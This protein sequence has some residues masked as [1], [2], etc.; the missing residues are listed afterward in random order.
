MIG[1]QQR[2]NINIDDVRQYNPSLAAMVLQD[3][4][5]M[6]KL[7]QEQLNQS[8]HAMQDSSQGKGEK[9]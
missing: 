4:V 1:R 5:E 9:A 7:F 3:P 8:I 6:I 2:L